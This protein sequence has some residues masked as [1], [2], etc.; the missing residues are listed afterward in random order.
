MHFSV[1]LLLSSSAPI[2]RKKCKMYDEKNLALCKNTYIFKTGQNKETWAKVFHRVF[3]Y[4]NAFGL[5]RS[6]SNTG[7]ARVNFIFY[8]ATPIIFKYIHLM[9]IRYEN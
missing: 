9:C 8:F 2:C 7:P 5:A 4:S 3:Y 6:K 1:A